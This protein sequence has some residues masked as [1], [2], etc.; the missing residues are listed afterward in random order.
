L[1]GGGGELDFVFC[2]TLTEK[3]KV[4]CTAAGVVCRKQ[5]IKMDLIFLSQNF[6]VLDEIFD[7]L[8]VTVHIPPNSRLFQLLKS[9]ETSP[10]VC[11]TS[12]TLISVQK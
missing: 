2:R 12:T 3:V 4:G 5:K 6:K 11:V 8:N 1:G 10:S 9:G 7:L